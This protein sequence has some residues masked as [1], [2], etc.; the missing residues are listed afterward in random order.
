MLDYDR[1][2]NRCGVPITMRLRWN[3]WKPFERASYMEH[4]HRFGVEPVRRERVVERVVLVPSHWPEPPE[5][6][7]KPKPPLHERI[8]F[9][10]ASVLVVL[11]AIAKWLGH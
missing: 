2:C 1:P 11:L 5:P 6:R 7:A 3:G 8:S 10:G 4:R 9:H